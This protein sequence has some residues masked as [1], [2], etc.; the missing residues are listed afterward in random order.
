MEYQ[1]GSGLLHSPSPRS[2]NQHSVRQYFQIRAAA[3][4]SAVTPTSSRFANIF[5]L[6]APPIWHPP[7]PASS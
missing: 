4:R 2:F 3:I 5:Q 7:A 6:R 1:A